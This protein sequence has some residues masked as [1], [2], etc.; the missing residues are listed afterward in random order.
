MPRKDAA[1]GPIT[2]QAQQD[3]VSEGI[4]NFELP[5]SLVTKIAKSAIPD[6]AKLQKETVLS[7]V[8]GSTVFI[9]YLAATAHDVA[10][11]KQHKSI[12]A[13]D[14]LKAL[15][16]I[17]FGDLV[18]M[19]QAE[20]QIYRDTTKGDK[21]RNKT[22]TA[23]TASSSASSNINN[24]KG[25]VKESGDASVSARAKGKEKAPPPPAQQ[26]QQQSPFTTV[27]RPLVSLSTSQDVAGDGTRREDDELGGEYDME[28]EGEGEGED[29]GDVEEEEEDP[30]EEEE[31]PVDMM[32]VEEEETRRDAAGLDEPM[33][34][35][36]ED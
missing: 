1:S 28:D 30:G 26:P 2:A 17:E 6:N 24:S 35:P 14:V 31:E 21:G 27:P 22:T 36:G 10:L 4:E 23:T 34:G 20:L 25:K 8:K 32:A 7:L 9:N 18:E 12:S 15:E 33:R 16:M 19:L 3:L 11:S 13:S 5:K 29:V